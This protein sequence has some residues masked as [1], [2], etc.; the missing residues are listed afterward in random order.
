MSVIFMV[1]NIQAILKK[2]LP[3]CLQ[4]THF[5]IGKRY[6][7]KVRDCYEQEHQLLMVATDRLSAFDRVLCAV[8]FKGQVLTLL[9]AWWYEKTRSM[10]PNALLNIPHPNVMVMKKCKV[11]PIEFVLRAYMTGSTDTSLYAEYQRGVR[12]VDGCVLEEGLKKNAKLPHH[13][14]TP[15]TKSDKHDESITL[16]EIIERSLMTKAELEEVSNKARALFDFGVWHAKQKGLILV[17]TKYEFGRDEAG[18]IVLVD[19]VHTPDSSRYWLADNYMARFDAGI[20]PESFDKEILRLWMKAQVDPY[21]NETLP[22]IPDDI[23][24]QL[25]ARYIELYERLTEKAFPLNDNIEN[26]AQIEHVLQLIK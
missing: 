16:D 8:P 19:E 26:D 3:H 23:I 15:T 7:G 18:N 5:T 13:L 1:N 11:F 10:V 24:L 17:D 12:Q 14:L 21:K 25:A 22:S 20:E 4:A 2:S 9:S 6:Q